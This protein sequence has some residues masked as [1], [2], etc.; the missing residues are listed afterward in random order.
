MTLFGIIVG[1]LYF[2]LDKDQNG[3][4][5][6]YKKNLIISLKIECFNCE[7]SIYYSL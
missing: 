5:N 7:L 2:Q 3:I 1:A 4:Q 6:R